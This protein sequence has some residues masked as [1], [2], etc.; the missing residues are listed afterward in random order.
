V[1]VG[2][3]AE[4]LDAPVEV[5]EDGVEIDDLLAIDLRMTRRTPWVAGWCGPMLMSISPSPTV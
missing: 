3:L 4:L 5:A 1:V 2:V